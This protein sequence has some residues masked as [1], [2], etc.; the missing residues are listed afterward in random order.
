M[1][2]VT[3]YAI[4]A[5]FAFAP[6]TFAQKWE[7]GAVAGGGFSNNLTATNATGSA[8]AGLAIGPAF[9]AIVSQNLYRRV[10]GEMRYTYQF[11]DLK[12]SANGESARFQGSTHA[13]HYDILVHSG[14]EHS[15]VRAF[16]AGGGGVRVFRGTGEEVTYQPLS[17]FALLTRTREA[18]PLVTFGG[19]IKCAISTHILLRV[20]VRDYFSAFPAKVIAPAPDAKLTGWL[21]GIVPMFG[22]TATI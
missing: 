12:L 9:G 22:I 4:A 14:S 1:K 18:K 11:S 6:A 5:L 2:A 20:E 16:V 13:F 8:K 10:S 21:H 7:I 19:G 15:R 17:D 3:Q